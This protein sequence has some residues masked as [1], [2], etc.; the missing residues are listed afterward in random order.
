MAKL[1]EGADRP[2][3]FRLSLRFVALGAISVCGGAGVVG[4][5]GRG[6]L[7]AALVLLA[8]VGCLGGASSGGSLGGGWPSPSD[9]VL[10]GEGISVRGK[11]LHG[12]CF[13]KERLRSVRLS[14][15]LWKSS[16]SLLL[17]GV[18]RRRR[19]LAMFR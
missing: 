16:I 3:V 5:V 14:S 12:A 8:N 10:V 13:C 4:A 11:S 6:V 18:I 19:M 15:P 9:W 17:V 2:S 7:I 1:V